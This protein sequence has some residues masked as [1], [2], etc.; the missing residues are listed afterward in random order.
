[1]K[2]VMVYM[3]LFAL[4]GVNIPVSAATPA[5]PNMF[6]SKEAAVAAL[7][8]GN[9]TAYEP[10]YF[11]LKGLNQV[12][13][14][15]K[16]AVPLEADAV[17]YMLTTAGWQWVIELRGTM[18]RW[19]VGL[20]GTVTPYALDVCGNSAKEVYYP[21]AP[22]P[23]PPPPGPE[24]KVVEPPP[25]PPAP[26]PAPTVKLVADK[27]KVTAGKPVVLTWTSANADYCVM[28]WVNTQ[29]TQGSAT[30]TPM[31][32]TTYTITAYGRDGQTATDTV[33]VTVKSG[34]GKKA[35][36]TVLGVVAGLVLL[37][38]LGGGHGGPGG[39]SF[40]STGGAH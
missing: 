21:P 26:L 23:P 24:V 18:F 35:L 33:T 5:A 28:Q 8:S 4:I 30:V 19:N 11:G 17:V 10:Q 40:G 15:T 31:V 20:D 2:Q 7:R 38:N 39:H 29:A 14:T 37:N 1:M 34:K 13:G 22:E 27:T 12:N 9:F 16:V 32:T 6:P 36:L 3:L 25:P